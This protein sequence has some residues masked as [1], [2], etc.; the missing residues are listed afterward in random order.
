MFDIDTITTINR[1]EEGMREAEFDHDDNRRQELSEQRA[2]D[3][4]EQR[5]MDA[6]PSEPDNHEY[7]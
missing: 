3:Q 2:E 4:N 7:F 5:E 6:Y 1:E